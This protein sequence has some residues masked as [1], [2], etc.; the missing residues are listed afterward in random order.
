LIAAV[1]LDERR[2]RE[3]MTEAV[4]IEDHVKEGGREEEEEG[5][6]EEDGGFESGSG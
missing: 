6:E 4:G 2:E 5:E 3:D 1:V